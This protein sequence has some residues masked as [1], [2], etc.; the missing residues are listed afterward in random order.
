MR[1]VS[2]IALAASALAAVSSAQ[3]IWEYRVVGGSATSGRLEAR[4]SSAAVWGTVCDDFFGGSDATVAC[5]SLGFSTANPSYSTATASMQGSATQPVVMDDVLCHGIEPSLDAC[6]FNGAA[7]GNCGHDEAIVL[8]CPGP[9]TSPPSVPPA[10]PSGTWQYRLAGSGSTTH[11]RLE[12]RDGATAAWGTVCDDYFGLLDT[13]VA[14]RALGFDTANVSYR[15]VTAYERGALTQ[16]VALDDLSCTGTEATLDACT[17]S[18]SRS[19]CDA[20][21]AIAI[22]CAGAAVPVFSTTVTATSYTYRLAGGD[23]ST[24]GRLEVLPASPATASWGLVCDDLFDINDA[25]VACRSL[26][27]STTSVGYRTVLPSE[28]L[29]LGT[30]M[31]MDDLQ[32]SGTEANLG[33]CLK[34]SFANCNPDESVVLSCGTGFVV[35]TATAVGSAVSSATTTPNGPGA[36]HPAASPALASA[37][38]TLAS[39]PRIAAAAAGLSTAMAFVIAAV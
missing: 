15:A 39:D 8:S 12:A 3:T 30:F 4:A 29:P 10:T 21:E 20:S 32:C 36:T 5:R 17:R 1:R 23:G 14:C 34:A 18:A 9:V 38:A 31:Y 11:G 37:A 22:N 33:A 19:N 26:G 6:Q 35:P 16:P 13:R 24:W 28:T 27:L 2:I 25:R 7:S